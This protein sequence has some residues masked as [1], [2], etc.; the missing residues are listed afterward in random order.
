L[1]G[2]KNDR[3]QQVKEGLEIYVDLWKKAIQRG[4]VSESDTVSEALAKLEKR[5]G[6]YT[7]T[8]D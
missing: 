7:A 8:E 6:L 5:G 4:V 3:P 2:T 1:E